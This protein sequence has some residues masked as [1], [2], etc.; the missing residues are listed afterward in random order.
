MFAVLAVLRLFSLIAA[1]IDH[2]DI[3]VACVLFDPCV[4]DDVDIGLGIVALLLPIV[5]MRCACW[6][7]CMSSA[8]DGDWNCELPLPMLCDCIDG[9]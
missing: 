3:L 6:A 5:D 7:M 4:L 2:L 8:V 1:P 9:G